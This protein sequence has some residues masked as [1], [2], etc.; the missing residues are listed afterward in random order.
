MGLNLKSSSFGTSILSKPYTTEQTD[1]LQRE[2]ERIE[3][4]IDDWNTAKHRLHRLDTV[5]R[6]N[7]S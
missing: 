1:N 4:I 5:S 2:I 7:Q 3:G 6:A